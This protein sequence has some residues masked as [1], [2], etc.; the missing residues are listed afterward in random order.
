MDSVSNVGVLDKA[1]GVLHAIERHGPQ[2]LIDLQSATDLPRATLHRLA[3]ALERH[4]LLRRDQAG[5]FC[6]GLGLV[7]L[8][9]VA[10]ETFPIASL[11][12]PRLADLCQHTGE[13][14]QLYVRDG[15]RRRCAVSF[16]SPHGLRWMVGEGALLPLHL[17]SAGR[18]LTGEVGRDG[19]VETVEE[20][21]PGVAS[22]SAPI[23]GESIGVLAA[24]SVGGPIER[25][26][27]E[28]GKRF[29]ADVVDA[30]TD[31]AAM[32]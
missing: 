24:V 13:S 22:V 23:S 5:R 12:R 3:V 21:E 9:H 28:P 32:L 15:E 29:G 26:S 10:N 2:S 20:R 16:P 19:W 1:I 11:S 30:A 14:V 8:G 18:V 17:G 31:I 4:G 7:A 6:L 25:L 27:R